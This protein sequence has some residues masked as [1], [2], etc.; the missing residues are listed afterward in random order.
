MLSDNYA[1]K[2]IRCNLHTEPYRTKQLSGPST[3][4]MWKKKDQEIKPSKTKKKKE[5]KVIRWQKEIP[6]DVEINL[7]GRTINWFNIKIEQEKTFL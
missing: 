1:N 4:I 6:L 7:T 2:F 3:L 5:N